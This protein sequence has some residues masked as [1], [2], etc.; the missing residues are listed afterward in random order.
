MKSLFQK[1]N[2]IKFGLL[3]TTLFFAILWIT[4]KKNNRGSEPQSKTQNISISESAEKWEKVVSLAKI[5]KEKLLDKYKER[6]ISFAEP[7]DVQIGDLYMQSYRDN[8]KPGQINTKAVIIGDTTLSFFIDY[9]FTN[10]LKSVQASFGR[11]DRALLSRNQRT[12]AILERHIANGRDVDGKFNLIFG[13]PMNPRPGRTATNYTL[14]FSVN[15]ISLYD[16]WNDV[17]P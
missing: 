12:D 5:Y 15:G 10:N 8:F 1:E 7:V 17:W 4:E 16:D 14:P 11:Y 9:L 2:L 3:L 6:K 13:L